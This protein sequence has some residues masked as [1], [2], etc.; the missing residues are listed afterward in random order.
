M[1]GADRF[2]G[3]YLSASPPRAMQNHSFP[4][5]D[6]NAYPWAQSHQEQKADART[7]TSCFSSFGGSFVDRQ[8]LFVCRV[9]SNV[10]TTCV[11]INPDSLS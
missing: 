10:R 1:N 6:S 7:L 4:G 9:C 2:T 8:G 3:S 5:R 11:A